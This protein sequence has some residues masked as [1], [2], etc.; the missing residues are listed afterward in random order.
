M[1]NVCRRT[2]LISEPQ[3]FR[4]MLYFPYMWAILK[5][6]CERAE[7]LAGR[8]DWLEPI[9]LKDDAVRLLGPYRVV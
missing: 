2:V 8:I 1:R 9:F 4:Q 6:E 3:S 5:S 7:A